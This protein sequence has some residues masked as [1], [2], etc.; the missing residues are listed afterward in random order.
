RNRVVIGLDATSPEKSLNRDRLEQEILST[1]VPRQAVLLIETTAAEP[2][3]GLQSKLRPAPGGVQILF[4]ISPPTYGVCTLGFNAFRG[5][6]FGF[7]INSHCTGVMGET[8]GQRYLQSL[9]PDGTIGT[10]IADFP[11]FTGSPCPPDRRCRYSDSAFAKYDNPRLGALG[12]IARPSSGDPELGSLTLKPVSARF[13]LTGRI[14][15]P[16]TGDIV[17]KVGRTTGWTYGTVVATCVD[18]RSAGT[19][20]FL[21]CQ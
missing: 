20:M 7:V 9:P 16:L 17:H 3:T 2:L 14:G 19:D 13:T 12:K 6:T 5:S 4:P 21:L 1:G 18:R 15:S 8:D 10:E 11:F